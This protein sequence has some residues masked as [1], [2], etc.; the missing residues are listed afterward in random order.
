MS[1]P[2][3]PGCLISGLRYVPEARDV[4]V[5]TPGVAKLSYAP[6]PTNGLLEKIEFAAEVGV[7]K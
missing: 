2:A 4:N 3:P 7:E 1:S 5:N 6:I